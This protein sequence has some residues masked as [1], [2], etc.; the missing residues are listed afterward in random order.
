MSRN[1]S[2]IKFL[3]ESTRTDTDSQHILL[4]NSLGVTTT[5]VL[6]LLL[7]GCAVGPKYQ[8]PSVVTPPTWSAEAPWR[9]AE[10]KDGIP[11]GTWWGLYQDAVLDQL[12]T[13]ALNANQ[14][15]TVVVQR[16]SNRL[17]KQVVPEPT[18]V[19]LFL[20]GGFIL[21]RQALARMTADNS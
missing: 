14:S 7:A 9:A 15:P 5:S 4:R 17:T 13:K 10:P 2:L 21:F 6:L 12:E 20:A 1:R 19:T 8:R 16:G 18:T 11:K 3:S